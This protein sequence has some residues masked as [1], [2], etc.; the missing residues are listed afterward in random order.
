M[1]GPSERM[2]F[3]VVPGS[4]S[5]RT[6]T[7]RE[8]LVRFSPNRRSRGGG[9]AKN[10]LTEPS[11]GCGQKRSPDA[12][13]GVLGA[14][15]A[16]IFGH[17]AIIDQKRLRVQ[18]RFLA[19]STRKLVPPPKNLQ[20]PSSQSATPPPGSISCGP[21]AE[22]N[23]WYSGTYPRLPNRVQR[24]RPERADV[25]M[26]RERAGPGRARRGKF[27]RPG[28][29]P[30]HIL[31]PCVLPSRIRCCWQLPSA[32]RP[33]AVRRRPTHPTLPPRLPAPQ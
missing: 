31:C 13:R 4:R 1:I 20:P 9:V 30:T 8:N 28:E 19:S 2:L 11:L 32:A 22:H 16:N 14:T 21:R 12:V 18:R 33:D 17:Y 27:G 24:R 6:S 23:R 15:G 5:T 26:W 7:C 10:G 3:V 29:L 25:V